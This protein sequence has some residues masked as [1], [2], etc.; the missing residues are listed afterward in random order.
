MCLIL[1]AYDCHPKYKLV[2]ASNRDEFY[3]RPT[4]PANFWP[5]NP[6]ILAG[7]DLKE[8]GTWMGITTSGRFAALTNYRDPARNKKM[9]P[10]GA[11]WYITTWQVP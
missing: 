3:N 1:F 2:V 4:S 6:D 9:L 7:K 8:G 5:D 10:P 11:T